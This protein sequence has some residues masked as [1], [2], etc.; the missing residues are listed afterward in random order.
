MNEN[1]TLDNQSDN[2]DIE[3]VNSDTENE[4]I[5][6]ENISDNPDY[7]EHDQVE[8]SDN[9]E[10]EEEET[11]SSTVIQ[12]TPDENSED[13]YT[14]SELDVNG[15]N[16]YISS[17]NEL[18]GVTPSS[19]DYYTFIEDDILEYFKG[20]M[21]LYPMNDYKAVHLRHW[22]QNTQYY[23][24]YDDYYYLWYDFPELECV[25]IVKYNGQANYVV[26]WTTQYDLNSSIV[27]GSQV[28]MSDFRKGVS[29]VQEMGLLCAVG[30]CLVLYIL[31]AI[32]KHLAR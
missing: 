4:I 18:L 6:D 1:N 23:S 19:N 21:S 28:G 12:V 11:P 7:M 32:F 8:V 3:V 31:H 16:A 27:Y 9:I 5:F 25:E 22:I 30:V 13:G 24:Y 29:Y 15:L 10:E 26:N 17:Q 20:I 14:I 2:L